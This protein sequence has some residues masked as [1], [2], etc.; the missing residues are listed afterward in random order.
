MNK[1][2]SLIS[3]IQKDDIESVEWIVRQMPYT[4]TTIYTGETV[5][6]F[7]A[8]GNYYKS[9]PMLIQYGAEIDVRIGSNKRSPLI[10]AAA[11]GAIDALKILLDN[12][13]DMKVVDGDGETAL[14]SAVKARSPECVSALLCANADKS[15]KDSLGL[16]AYDWAIKKKD[17]AIVEIFA[18]HVELGVLENLITGAEHHESNCLF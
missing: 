16:T 12:G 2:H 4:V 14:I 8:R 13:A 7:A 3:A 6:Q 18:A 17:V 11:F 10:M 9:I 5:L 15:I 1:T